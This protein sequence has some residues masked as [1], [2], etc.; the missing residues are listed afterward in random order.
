MRKSLIRAANKLL[1]VYKLELGQADLQQWIE[2]RFP[3][4]KEGVVTLTLKDPVVRLEPHDDRLGIELTVRGEIVKGL[5]LEGRW[6]VDGEPAYDCGKGELY[7]RNPAVRGINPALRIR[8]ANGSSSK[9]LMEEVLA[10][11]L[12]DVPVYKLERG[13]LGHALAKLCLKSVQ[14]RGDRLI[15]ELGLE[16]ENPPVR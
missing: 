13:R 7:L 12:S 5:A 9:G 16:A 1:S 10:G 6:M 15:A 3:I 2:S 14:V 11:A 8:S 4:R